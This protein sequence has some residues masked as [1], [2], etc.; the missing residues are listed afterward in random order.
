MKI[1][2]SLHRA[3]QSQWAAATAVVSHRQ[4]DVLEPHPEHAQG[5]G[6]PRQSRRH[7][8]RAAVCRRLRRLL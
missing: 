7:Q 8:P 3:G 5:D 1:D 6:R 4:L 2:Q